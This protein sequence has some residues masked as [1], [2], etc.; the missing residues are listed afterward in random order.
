MSLSP[1]AYALPRLRYGQ[2]IRPC[3]VGEEWFCDR[4][5]SA[6]G[7]QHKAKMGMPGTEWS[8]T[9]LKA[10]PKFFDVGDRNVRV[11]RAF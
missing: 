3:S 1:I 10:P 8:E 2:G 5:R 9:G 4:P 7:S 6:A 11:M